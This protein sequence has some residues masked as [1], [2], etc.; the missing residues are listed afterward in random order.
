MMIRQLPANQFTGNAIL[1]GKIVELITP[2]NMP[3]DSGP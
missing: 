2:H 3:F 1:L